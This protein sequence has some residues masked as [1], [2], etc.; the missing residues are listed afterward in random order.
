MTASQEKVE[1]HLQTE[2]M[3]MT[4]AGPARAAATTTLE[5]FEGL[6]ARANVADS[7]EARIG[8]CLILTIFEQFRAALCLIDGGHATHAAGPIRSMLEGVADLT[9]LSANAE[10]LDQL[11]YE[12]AR[13]NVAMFS[14]ILRLENVPEEIAATVKEW[15]ERDEPVRDELS[16]AGK[17]RILLETKLKNVDLVGMYL[18]YRILCAF[19]HP[20]LTAL[21]TRHAGRER[22]T[23]LE[24]CRL[25]DEPVLGMLLMI[26][27]DLLVRA[28]S[29]LHQFTDLSE[30]DV[31][32]VAEEAKRTWEA[33]QA[34]DG[35]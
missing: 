3:N 12:N 21:I 19:V 27:V 25:I 9:N 14:D 30:R 7:G 33:G 23:E 1:H 20:N 5:G 6:I 29:E 11:R 13:S 22:L 18:H 2:D 31:N 16:K 28:G 24:Y 15:K 26:A 10:Y 4:K 8:A 32:A 35:E 17:E 34:E